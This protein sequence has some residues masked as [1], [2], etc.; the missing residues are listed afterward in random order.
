VRIP[1]LERVPINRVAIF[2]VVLFA[3]ERL[4][5]TPLYICIG[6]GI[7]IMI[8]AFAF[9]AGGG[10]TRI[11]GAYVFFYSLLVVIIGLSYKAF[12]GEPVQTNLVDPRTDVYAYVATI[13]G[14]YAAIILSGR[15][16]RKTALLQNLLKEPQMYRASV[17]CIV[18]G[19][20][21]GF[22][23]TLLGGG[24]SLVQ[25]AF[26]Q[27]NQLVPLGIIIGVMYQIRRSGGTRSINLPTILGAGF[28][29]INDG[30]LGFSKQGLLEPFLCWLLPVSALRFR[31]SRWQVVS[32]LLFVLIFFRYLNPY[33]QYA[34]G[35]IPEFPTMTQRIDAAIPLLEHLDKTRQLYDKQVNAIQGPVGLNSYYNTPQGFWERLQMI[36][37]D[38]KLI[39]VTDR[40]RVI[41]LF[42]LKL[43]FINAVPHFLWPNKPGINP[44]NYYA[45]EI[46]GDATW[47]G[48]TTTGI[49]FSA[50]AEAYHV[51]KWVG[52]L[53]IAPILWC[54]LFLEYDA[55]FG[56]L[57][58]SPWGLLVLALISHV[59]SE[60]ALSNMIYMLTFG[61]EILVFCAF[62]TTWFAPLFAIPIL[63]PDRRRET[64]G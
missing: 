49:S 64:A 63:G 39:D 35:Q 34:R 3:L 55:L 38:D 33:A 26:G 31:L 56:D 58:T 20:T 13:T 40:G 15:F 60:G 37:V 6:F 2:T 1:F 17:G 16:S 14:L 48:D 19:V 23:I 62:F 46:N 53:V 10:L 8:A 28:M 61:V 9:N 30:I 22:I 59:A 7:F 44:G 29:L 25:S 24:G 51:A 18:F 43:A 52:V 12:L 32:I 27:L 21:G 11:T 50:T 41:G 42:P 47:E 54:M 5:G 45:H 4:E 36:S 57:R